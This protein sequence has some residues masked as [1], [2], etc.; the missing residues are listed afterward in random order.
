[1]YM[2]TKNVSLSSLG[3][4]AFVED[5]TT[6]GASFLMLL[7]TVALVAA[8]LLPGAS[9]RPRPLRLLATRMTLHDP[10]QSC[11]G[12]PGASA[13]VSSG[14]PEGASLQ[15]ERYIWERAPCLRGAIEAAKRDDQQLAAMAQYEAAI[16]Q[17]ST[18]LRPS[19][20]FEVRKA[21]EVAFLA[22]L[23]QSRRSGEPYITHP[24]EVA[25]ILGRTQID[26]ETV[27]AGP[28]GGEQ[29]WN[30]LSAAAARI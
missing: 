25:V 23:G 8:L 14:A 5:R 26:A 1:M 27:C 16:R 17:S 30:A 4:A 11:D 19:A 3:L 2:Y 21:L 12:A 28:G 22:H 10:F 13:E 18:Y 24:V 29:D 20:H 15:F 9:R 6:L 7:A